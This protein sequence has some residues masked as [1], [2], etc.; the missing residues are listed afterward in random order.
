MND[1]QDMN[2]LQIDD[3]PYRLC[4]DLE[5]TNRCNAL[6]TFCPRDKT[7]SQGFMSDS[8]FYKA[9]DYAQNENVFVSL[10]G[11]GESMIHP[12]FIEYVQEIKKRGLSCQITTN[13]SLLT[14][15]ITDFLLSV[16]IDKINF[17]VSNL[18]GDYDAV[19]NLSFEK[20]IKNIKYF[21]RKN[22]GRCVVQV[23]IVKNKENAKKHREMREFWVGLGVHL[24]NIE[25]LDQSTRAG[26]C[27]TDHF[28][29]DTNDF[30]KEAILIAKNNRVN[31][32]LIPFAV[33]SIGWNGNHYLCC[34]DY[35]KKDPLASIDEMDLCEVNAEKVKRVLDSDRSI[36]RKCSLDPVGQI[37]EC[38]IRINRG[39]LE[40]SSL[41][42]V[43][44]KLR[45]RRQRLKGFGGNCD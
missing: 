32:C 19:Y 4:L 44:E 43:L 10:T 11:Q 23:S 20:T 6:C 2:E 34:H 18:W 27:K 35:E 42:R 9:L 5:L 30:R 16:C 31:G 12:R 28:F 37:Q 29:V 39:E 41:D 40:S 38:L 1:Q 14:E 26:A 8:H 33:P 24:D 7:P 17:S 15:S 13:A 21:I 36:C 22:D 3:P 45:K 25:M